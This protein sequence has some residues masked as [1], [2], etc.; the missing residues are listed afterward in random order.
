VILFLLDAAL[1]TTIGLL[2]GYFYKIKDKV[3]VVDTI[4]T[5]TLPMNGLCL[6]A[7]WTT[8]AS[9]INLTAAAQSTTSISNVNMA[10]VS[11]TL[12]LVIL[13]TYFILENTVLRLYGFRY[14]FSVYPVV[15]W[16]LVGV[17]VAQRGSEDIKRN[18][19]YTLILLLLAIMMLIVKLVL[20][21]WRF[22]V[23]VRAEQ[24]LNPKRI[25]M[26]MSGRKQTY[27]NC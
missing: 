5:Y 12:L 16:A 9:L 27:D 23:A 19:I 25:F 11:L 20:F 18:N 6:Y 21:A 14:V 17:L 10:T 26:Q 4:L 2:F 15:T 7:T 3:S 22:L 1:Y 24:S 13:L 8:I